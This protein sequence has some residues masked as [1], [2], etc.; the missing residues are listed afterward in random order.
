MLP[1]MP[2]PGIRPRN[3]LAT[4]A[5]RKSIDG[6][7]ALAARRQILRR[8]AVE[9]DLPCRSA[10]ARRQIPAAAAHIGPFDQPLVRQ[11]ALDADGVAHVLRV[12]EGDGGEPLEILPEERVGAERGTSRLDHAIDERVGQVSAEGQA[13][14]VGDHDRR[15]LREARLEVTEDDGRHGIHAPSAAQDGLVVQRIDKPGPR[16]EVARVRVVEAGV[17]VGRELDTALRIE[18]CHGKLGNGARRVGRAGGGVDGNRRGRIE[19]A[20]VPVL[21][22][23]GGPFVLVAQAEIHRQLRADAPVV[24]HEHAMVRRRVQTLRVAGDGTAGRN[25]QHEGGD[26]LSELVGGRAAGTRV[27]AL[28][29]VAAADRTRIHLALTVETQVVTGANRM[30]A[31]DPACTS[32]APSRCCGNVVPPRLSPM[33]DN[34]AKSNNGK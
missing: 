17:F 1:L 30:T 27:G 8:R 11:L 20:H 2:T 16:L 19:T 29:H 5:L 22:V 21:R 24:L 23:G 12:V 15:R 31:P 26:V 14:V 10:A 13:V 3:G 28:E 18:R 33:S 32:V 7:I 25:A 6:L 4:L 34:E 9:F